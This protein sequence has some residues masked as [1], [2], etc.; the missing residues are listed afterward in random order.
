MT[1]EECH[2]VATVVHASPAGSYA[3]TYCGRARALGDGG[4]PALTWDVARADCE[5]CL[6]C[7]AEASH[8]ATVP[9]VEER[10]GS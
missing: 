3:V 5:T 9:R 10:S 2:L 6:D 4:D 1:R 8:A 7:H